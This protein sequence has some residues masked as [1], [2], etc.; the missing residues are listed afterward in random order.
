GQ[1][2]R[3]DLLAL[4]HA[5][6]LRVHLYQGKLDAAHQLAASASAQAASA[7]VHN[8]TCWIAGNICLARGAY[9]DALAFYQ[10]S[11]QINTSYGGETRSHGALMIGFTRLALDQ[12]D[13]AER[14]LATSMTLPTTDSPII[15]LYAL[16]GLACV[17]TRRGEYALAC[18]RA[19]EVRDQL[20]RR[21]HNHRLMEL[22][23]TL[24]KNL[25]EGITT[26]TITSLII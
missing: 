9:R 23:T 5:F 19:E 25:A 1:K 11:S 15:D 22:I 24:L 3:A 6:L 7:V 16:Y 8:R 26:V 18:K 21:C 2:D 17:A 10:E 13:E 12:I 14:Q 4:G 20:Q